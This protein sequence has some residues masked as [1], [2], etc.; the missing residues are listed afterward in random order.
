MKK[1]LVRAT[2]S[3]PDSGG[4]KVHAVAAHPVAAGAGLADHQAR[5]VFVGQPARH[6]EQVLPEFFFG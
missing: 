4:W 1:A 2:C 3:A 6:L 5:Q